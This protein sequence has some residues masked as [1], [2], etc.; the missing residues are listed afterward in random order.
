M[1]DLL[2]L[3]DN[4]VL[5][6][7]LVGPLGVGVGLVGGVALDGV[8]LVDLGSVLELVE[9][10]SQCLWPPSAWRLVVRAEGWGLL[11][12]DPVFKLD[13]ER[14]W[15]FV[16]CWGLLFKDPVFKLDIERWWSF[17]GGWCLLFKDPVFKLD[18]DLLWS[19]IE[20]W[21]LG[22]R[23]GLL[24]GCFLESVADVSNQFLFASETVVVLFKVLDRAA[25]DKLAYNDFM[26]T[27]K[28]AFWL[29]VPDSAL[30]SDPGVPPRVSLKDMA[31]LKRPSRS[32]SKSDL[33]LPVD[34]WCSLWGFL[35]CNSCLASAYWGDRDIERD[36]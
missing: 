30:T 31:L 13:I 15:S 28:L 3:M 36:R 6:T 19:L 26:E 16:G 22:L 32:L 11:F 9:W 8:V 35:A 34:L 29:G 23:G 33:M 20:D 1:D 25:F 14:W 2:L 10:T 24:G 12:K 4:L 7:L 27:R 21:L 5:F 17:V 18:M